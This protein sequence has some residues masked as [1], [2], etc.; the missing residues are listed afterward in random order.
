MEDVLSW[1]AWWGVLPLPDLL[2]PAVLVWRDEGKSLLPPLLCLP[3]RRGL[4]KPHAAHV[5]TSAI[6][7][8]SKPATSSL[9]LMLFVPARH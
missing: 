5:H 2:L 6:S 4:S 8:P 3:L 9:W 7:A 1:A